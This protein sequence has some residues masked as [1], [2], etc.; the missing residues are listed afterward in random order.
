MANGPSTPHGPFC[1][2]LYVAEVHQGLGIAARARYLKSTGLFDATGCHLVNVPLKEDVAVLAYF[3]GA[4]SL[5][6][7]P[8]GNVF[9]IEDLSVRPGGELFMDAHGVS[10]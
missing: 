7:S 2:L 8:G 10:L 6:I 3:N 5:D 9:V 1:S 4:A